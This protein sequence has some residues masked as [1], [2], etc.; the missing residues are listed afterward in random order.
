M[1]TL[2]KGISPSFINYLENN[3]LPFNII[4]YCTEAYMKDYKDTSDPFVHPILMNDY[5]IKQLPPVRIVHGSSD[6]H[7]DMILRFITK[8]T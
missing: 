8:L 2:D 6:P 5:I 4:K 3:I 7:R 1:F